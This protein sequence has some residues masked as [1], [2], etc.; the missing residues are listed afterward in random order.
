MATLLHREQGVVGTGERARR[1]QAGSAPQPL[2]ESA[3]LVACHDHHSALPGSPAL[4]GDV[5]ESLLF[6]SARPMGETMSLM[7]FVTL[8]ADTLLVVIT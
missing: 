8:P 3:A 6:A 1:A 2:A 7:S 5:P 4:I